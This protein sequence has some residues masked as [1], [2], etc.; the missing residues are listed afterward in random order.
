MR[1]AKMTNKLE[2]WRLQSQ[3]SNHFKV[4]ALWL[5]PELDCSASIDDVLPASGEEQLAYYVDYIRRRY[6]H[7]WNADAVPIYWSVM[8]DGDG[9][10]SEEAPFH[11]ADSIGNV[12]TYYYPPINVRTGNLIN[13]YRL[14]VIN[15]R[16]PEFAA[17]LGWLPAPGQLFAPLRSIVNGSPQPARRNLTGLAAV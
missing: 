12:L 4:T 10:G 13:W 3:E 15:N 8:G 1:N 5:Y 14:P 9:F 16:F 11:D 17:A 7:W 2:K 6:P